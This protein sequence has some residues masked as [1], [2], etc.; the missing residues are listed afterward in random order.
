[1]HLGLADSVGAVPDSDTGSLFLCF[2]WLS[3]A[4][5]LAGL[6]T[7]S[8]HRIPHCIAIASAMPR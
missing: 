1:M 7:G 6:D 4:Q 5:G 2:G 3:L 8:L